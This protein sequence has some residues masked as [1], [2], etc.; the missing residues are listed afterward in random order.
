MK[1]HKALQLM[2]TLWRFL[3]GI[4]VAFGSLAAVLV[5]LAFTPAPFWTWYRMSMKNAGVNRPPDYL[6]LLGGGGMPS[7]SGLIRTWYAAKT[8]N[9]FNRA[10]IIVALPG[11]RNDSLSSVNLMKKELNLRGISRERIFLEDSGT[12][13][14]AQAVNIFNSSRVTRHSSILIV[15]SPVHLYRAVL[16]FKKAGFIKVDGLPA[17]EQ[18]IESDITFNAYKL[19][20]RKFI[21]DVGS[22]ITL[23]YQFWTQ[24][25]YELLILREWAA[26]GY[27]KLMGWI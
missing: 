17:F 15:T 22:N 26:L 7:E 5:I 20:G 8:G 3:K 2:K 27:Y 25:N 1:N 9:Y 10:R 6:V 23:R 13:T 21:P 24:M 12:N 4:L 19:G 18:T 16:S 14:R 11:D